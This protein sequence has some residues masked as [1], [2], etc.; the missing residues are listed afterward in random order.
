MNGLCRI[1][2]GSRDIISGSLQHIFS[3]I[4]DKMHSYTVR[5]AHFAL[6]SLWHEGLSHNYKKIQ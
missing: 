2:E 1:S 5:T 6:L 3:V 4:G